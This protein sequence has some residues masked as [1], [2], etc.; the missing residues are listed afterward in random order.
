MNLQDREENRRNN[1]V[2]GALINNNDAEVKEKEVFKAKSYYL[3][4][5]LYKAVGL[6]AAL[7]GVDKS[8]VVREALNI[9]LKDILENLEQLMKLKSK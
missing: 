1:S 5:A 4:E 8:A 3:S 9:Y 6:K 7:I 2:V